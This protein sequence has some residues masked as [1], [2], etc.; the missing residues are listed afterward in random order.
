MILRRFASLLFAGVFLAATDA[1]RSPSAWR[2]SSLL[3]KRTDHNQYFKTRL[4]YESAKD[5]PSN[6]G[7]SSSSNMWTVLATTER[8]LSSILGKPTADNPFTRKEVA[9]VCEPHDD[10]AMFI[11]NVWRRLREAREMGEVHGQLE[12]DKRLE[13]GRSM[14]TTSHC[15]S[16]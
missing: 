1:F 10:D 7:G 13:Q 4:M 6:S 12:E 5:P 11:A 3:T 2:R 15:T 8:W 14:T 16:Y 9:Y